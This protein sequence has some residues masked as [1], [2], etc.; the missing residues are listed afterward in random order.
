[1][2]AVAILDQVEISGL[3]DIGDYSFGQSF[4]LDM[5][6]VEMR[7]DIIAFRRDIAGV[8]LFTLYIDGYSADVSIEN[9]ARMLDQRI[10]LTL[11]TSS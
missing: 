9:L 3:E 7:V 4:M 10:L 8:L 5:E 6:A 11:E 2:E 1:L